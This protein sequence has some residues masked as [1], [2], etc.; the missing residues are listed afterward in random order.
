LRYAL[1]PANPLSGEHPT[2]CDLLEPGSAVLAAAE[3]AE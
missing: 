2:I 3:R 1:D